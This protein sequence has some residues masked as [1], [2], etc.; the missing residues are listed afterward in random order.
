[1]IKLRGANMPAT[2]RDPLSAPLTNLNWLYFRVSPQTF[3][4]LNW[5][6]GATVGGAVIYFQF[7][8]FCLVQ[9]IWYS[10]QNYRVI[11]EFSLFIKFSSVLWNIKVF[12]HIYWVFYRVS[13]CVCAS[14]HNILCSVCH[15]KKHLSF[16][17]TYFKITK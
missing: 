10:P 12:Y 8:S 13:R 7:A 15:H 1:M 6:K 11:V 16:H 2:L 3:G 17:T 4:F 5:I 14:I 9:N